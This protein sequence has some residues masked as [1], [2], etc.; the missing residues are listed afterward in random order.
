[1]T[2]VRSQVLFMKLVSHLLFVFWAY[3]QA[4]G[5]LWKME[6]C[7]FSRMCFQACQGNVKLLLGVEMLE[8][9]PPSC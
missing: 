4:K 6:L 9:D 3:F 8:E 5:L 7:L 1:M 2:K